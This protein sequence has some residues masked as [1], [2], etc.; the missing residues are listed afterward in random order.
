[1]IVTAGQQGRMVLDVTPTSKADDIV[2]LPCG[3][4]VMML[5]GVTPWQSQMFFWILTFWL[6]AQVF[7]DDPPHGK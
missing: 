4:K 2:C 7:L 6:H 3:Y 1:V 5:L